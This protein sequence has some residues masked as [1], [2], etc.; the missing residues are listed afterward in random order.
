MTE[1]A[2]I[3]KGDTFLRR[4]GYELDD[5]TL[6]TL[7]G[8]YSCAIRVPGTAVDRP[9]T[10]IGP[11]DDG[12]ANKRF[13][14]SLTPAETVLFA[15]GQYI[16][17]VEI[18]NAALTPPLRVETHIILTVNEHIVGSTYVPDL[19]DRTAELTQLRTNLIECRAAM[20]EYFTG[21]VVQKVRGGRYGTEMWYAAPKSFA[22]YQE[23]EAHLERKIAELES[24]A[25]GGR[26]RSAIVGVW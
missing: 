18:T 13:L 15:A 14:A 21:G 17:A 25:A 7:P 9:V 19:G 1:T 11:D 2:L 12:T 26:A 5:G 8:S 16:V 4:F 23:L 10:D 20:M 6:A 24:V 3:Y 22:E